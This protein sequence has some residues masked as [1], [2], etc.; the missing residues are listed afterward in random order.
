MNTIN[1]CVKRVRQ[2]CDL[3]P[4]VLRHLKRVGPLLMIASVLVYLLLGAAAFLSLEH[5]THEHEISRFY[6]NFGVRRRQFS[7]E[8]TK[9]LF[10]KNENML[11]IVDQANTQRLQ[12]V[13]NKQL[14]DY[15][16]ELPLELPNRQ[17]WTMT[18]SLNF[19]WGLLTTLGHGSRSPETT[20]GQIF[21]LFYALLGVPFFF[22]T[23]LICACS[24]LRWIRANDHFPGKMNDFHLLA[25][26]FGV[27][28]WFLA[29]FTILLYSSATTESFW[30]S[31]YTAVLS[32]FTVAFSELDKVITLSGTT[33]SLFLCSLILCSIFGVLTKKTHQSAAMDQ[34]FN[35]GNPVHVIHAEDVTQTPPLAAPRFK[36]VVDQSG[37]SSLSDSNRKVRE[38]HHY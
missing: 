14:R 21:A 24:V 16:N 25:A 12:D 9:A 3:S 7:R 4:D 13:L 28:S 36:V 8:M 22:S 6:L 31:F 32:A 30:L 38:I 5:S 35:G 37:G 1:R 19:A 18:N 15:E 11:I 34:Q 10:E 29:A 20:G 2:S 27:F 17:A 33:I 26:S 23:I